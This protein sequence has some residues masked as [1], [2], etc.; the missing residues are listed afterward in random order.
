MGSDGLDLRSLLAAAEE[1]SPVYVVDVV[2]AE[3]AQAIDAQHVALLIA[4]FSGSA[5]VR[6]SHVTG[7]GREQ[8]GHDERITNL[9]LPGTAYERVLYSQHLEVVAEGDGD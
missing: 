5:L 8:E 3:L 6:L 2:A 7:V 9:P 1:S 4:D